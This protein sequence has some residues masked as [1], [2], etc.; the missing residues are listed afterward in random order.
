MLLRIVWIFFVLASCAD[1]ERIDDIHFGN[2]SSEDDHGFKSESCESYEGVLK[3]SARRLLPRKSNWLGG[4]LEFRMKV[5]PDKLNYFTGKFWGGDLTGEASRL[6]LED[7]QYFVAVQ[8]MIKG[9]GG[10]RFKALLRVP[11][12]LI[13]I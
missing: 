11:L 3:A 1:A 7:N 2:K 12:S 9:R 6:M 8:K 5:D 4:R 13:H 10:N